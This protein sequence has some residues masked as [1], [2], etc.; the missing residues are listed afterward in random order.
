MRREPD[1]RARVERGGD[2][3]GRDVELVGV[4]GVEGRA[5]VLPVVG[6]RR[7]DLLLGGEQHGGVRREVEE[8]GEAVDGQQLGDVRPRLGVV[9][10]LD[11]GHLRQLAVLDGE[12]GGRRDLDLGRLAERALGERREPAQRLDLDVEH[13]DAHGA[14]LGRRVDVEQAAAGRELAAVVD[15]VDA[16]VARRD[17]VAHAVVEVEQVADAQREG[18]RAQARVGDLLGER[19]GGHDDDRRRG[20]AG[21]QERV[22][23]R[24]AQADE[25]RRRR[26]V[27]LVRDAAARVEA[28]PPRVQPRAQV[29][30]EIARLA[31]VAGDDERRARGV[32]VGERRQDVR[33]QRRGRERA[34]AVARERRRAGVVGE[35]VKEGAQGHRT[36]AA[37]AGGR[38]RRL[39]LGPRPTPPPGVRSGSRSPST[40]AS[41][42]FAARSTRS[43]TSALGSANAPRTCAETISG[44]VESGRPTPIR[45]RAK[46]APPSC[47]FSDFRPL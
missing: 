16:L 31:V 1:A 30:G 5:D 43:A 6:E 21:F 9:P 45:T 4:V 23:R 22:Q 40:I 39:S 32:L 35:V 14:V 7:A 10:K 18:V 2:R 19:D 28:H 37:T 11:G 46:S 29:A 3:V 27:R 38:G 25:M 17:E 13:V 20:A 12:L 24:D 15:L 26:E 33:P 36:G 44:S 41:A 8:R 42:A 34:P 47:A